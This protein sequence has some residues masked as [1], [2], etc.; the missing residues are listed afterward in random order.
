MKSDDWDAWR[1]NCWGNEE[2]ID[3][4]ATCSA[5]YSRAYISAYNSN[6]Y[7]LDFPQCYDDED[8]NLD[9]MDR[10]EPEFWRF[11]NYKDAHIHHAAR[12]FMENVLTH[13]NYDEL[14]M[15]MEKSKLQLLHDRIAQRLALETAPVDVESPVQGIP[16]Q[17]A[18]GQAPRKQMQ[19][20]HNIGRK[21]RG[22]GASHAERDLEI[23][24]RQ[25][26]VA[27][28]VAAVS[29]EQNVQ[30]YDGYLPCI[31][32]DMADYLNLPQ[33]QEALHV[34]ETEWEM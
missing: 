12:G 4:D 14:N 2:A 9:L 7:A 30:E 31:A 32:Y 25:E 1:Q 33:V 20:V 28:G 10:P 6:V 3:S 27:A 19:P 29:A 26:A 5:V 21:P 11:Y 18:Q 16:Q 17:P 34:K 22:G 15:N 23:A 8:W 13:H 24:R